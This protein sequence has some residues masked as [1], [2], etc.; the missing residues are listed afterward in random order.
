MVLVRS[1]RRALSTVVTTAI[2]LTAVSVIVTGVVALANTNSRTFETL[3]VSSSSDKL[4]KINEMPK[5]ENVFLYTGFGS[6]NK[7]NITVSNVGTV[8]FNV[9]KI[10]IS[11]TGNCQT[12]P[13]SS[14]AGNDPTC[15][16]GSIQSCSHPSYDTNSCK[17]IKPKDS[18]WYY[19]IYPPGDSG[20]LTNISV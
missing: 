3:L 20:V 16:N 9:T 6:I 11:S 8:G 2:M 7:I 4:N 13:T 15:S 18:R 5:I 14:T 10:T 19:V 1:K 12:Y 17:S